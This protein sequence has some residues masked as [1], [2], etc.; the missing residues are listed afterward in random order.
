MIAEVKKHP[1]DYLI[2]GFT[3]VFGLTTIL[4]FRLRPPIKQTAIIATALAYVAWGYWHHRR[5]G[6]FRIKLMLEYILVATLGV[7]IINSVL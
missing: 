3:L 5:L 6:L 7:L 2:L 1:L 4:L